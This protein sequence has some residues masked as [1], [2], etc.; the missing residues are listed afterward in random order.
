MTVKIH[1]INSGTV[2]EMKQ[3]VRYYVNR[4]DKIAYQKLFNYFKRNQVRME[5]ENM[6]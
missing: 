2:I 5:N 3:K 4:G 1:I 6:G